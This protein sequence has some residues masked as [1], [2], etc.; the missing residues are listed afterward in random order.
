MNQL[1][2]GKISKIVK[3][4]VIAIYVSYYCESHFFFHTHVFS[5][6]TVTHSHPYMPSGGHSHSVVECQ[7]IAS[8]TNMF[9]TLVDTMFIAIACLFFILLHTNTLRSIVGSIIKNPS[10]RAPPVSFC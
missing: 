10:L 3:F 4:L 8:L 1:M 7:T 9:S 2:K 5:W 6:G